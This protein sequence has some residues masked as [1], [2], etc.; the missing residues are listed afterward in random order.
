MPASASSTIPKISIIHS[1]WHEASKPISTA[2]RAAIL[3]RRASASTFLASFALPNISAPARTIS[4]NI[5]R[6]SPLS[7]LLSSRAAKNLQCYADSELVVK[8]ING[9]YQVKNEGIRLLYDCALRWIA[10]IPRFSISHV[11]REKIKKPTSSPILRWILAATP[12]WDVTAASGTLS[13]NPRN[14]RLCLV[15]YNH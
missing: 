14:P 11:R 4:P 1:K 13:I 15:S 10:M 9:E 2:A 5:P 12:E 7:D 8:Q 6:S 3:A